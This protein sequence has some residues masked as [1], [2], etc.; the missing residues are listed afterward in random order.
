MES[1]K[2][3]LIAVLIAGIFIGTNAL[4]IVIG[5][6]PYRLGLDD[7]WHETNSDVDK[8]DN[9][10]YLVTG[11]PLGGMPMLFSLNEDPKANR[12]YE[13]DQYANVLWE[14]TNQWFLHEV[15]MIT[16]GYSSKKAVLV[17]NAAIYGVLQATVEQDG[18]GSFSSDD[19]WE[20]RPEVVNWT[21]V[22]PSWDQS[23]PINNPTGDY[24]YYVINDVDYINGTDYGTN[25]DS[26]LVSMKAFNLVFLLNY[27][28]EMLERSAGDYWG[29]A[30]NI[31]WYYGD[32]ND[33]TIL[34]EQHNPDMLSN[35]NLVIADSANR[36]VIEV[37]RTTK[38]IEWELTEADGQAFRWVKDADYQTDTDSFLITDSSNNRIVNMKL[39]GDV[40]WT[41]THPE[42]VI[43]H[44]ADL[45]ADG[46]LVVGTST[47]GSIID[48]DPLNQQDIV[49]IKMNSLFNSEPHIDLIE[50]LTIFNPIGLIAI[51]IPFTTKFTLTVRETHRTENGVRK[52]QIMPDLV[53]SIVIIGIL[54]IFLFVG[55]GLLNLVTTLIMNLGLN[56]IP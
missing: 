29:N 56:M 53:S 9:G 28:Q 49:V 54:T 16:S 8:L 23:H 31:Y 2:K 42:L 12:I 38:N 27:T 26:L 18:G 48:V 22:N 3:R 33:S 21:E 15:E 44:E 50:F 19:E 46:R 35:G 5:L 14:I 24:A 39:N 40:L 7:C 37:N 52:S 41:F 32:P 10:N 13:V 6:Y 51:V 34:N 25:Y 4:V 55:E 47:S 43:P 11:F 17:A 30:S 1:N 36:R 20:F 45:T